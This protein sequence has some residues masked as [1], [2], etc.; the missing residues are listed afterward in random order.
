MDPVVFKLNLARFV[1]SPGLARLVALAG[2]EHH[3]AREHTGA[4]RRGGE[5]TG[6]PD[7][8][9]HADEASRQ[10]V[11]ARLNLGSKIRGQPMSFETTSFNSVRTVQTPGDSVILTAETWHP[12]CVSMKIHELM[13]FCSEDGNQF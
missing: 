13:R 6:L 2:A 10:R 3:N 7:S 8:D 5:P 9:W 11:R 4:G 12:I 1:G